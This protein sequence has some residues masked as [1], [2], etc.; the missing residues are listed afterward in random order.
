M[1]S[2]EKVSNTKMPDQDDML[3]IIPEKPPSEMVLELRMTGRERHR[4]HRHIRVLLGILFAV[5]LVRF[6]LW[7]GGGEEFFWSAAAGVLPPLFWLWFWLKEDAVH[8]EPKRAVFRAF[9]FGALMLPLAVAIERVGDIFLRKSLGIPAADVLQIDLLPAG[10]IL[11]LFFLWA[12][13]EETMKYLAASSAEFRTAEYDEP[14]DAAVYLISAAVGFSALE[15][16][17]YIWQTVLH[18][19]VLD[20]VI[21]AHLRFMGAGLLHIVASSFLGLFIGFSFYKSPR[22]RQAY[23]WAGL[24]LAISLHALFNYF[25]LSDRGENAFGT[26]LFLWLAAIVALLLFEKVKYV[27]QET[28][29]S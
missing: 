2:Y 28:K 6:F 9:F 3:P 12:L 21:L 5:S 16:I 1:V 27:R 17:F 14:I 19:G 7:R 10:I 4:H 13:V 24:F 20:G 29:N 18:N 26:F 15:N 25:I 23:F 8:P 22:A 11:A